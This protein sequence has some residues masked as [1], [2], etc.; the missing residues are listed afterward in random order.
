MR[1]KKG[2]QLNPGQ[3]IIPVG[4][5]N[6]PEPHEMDA[7]MIL[8]RH[9]Q[10]TIEFLAPVDDFKR[11]TADV[12]MLGVIWEIK[13]PKG[14]SKSTIGTQFSRASR[15]SKNIVL[16][17]RRTKLEYERIEKKVIL[18]VKQRTALNKVILINKS[19]KVI[20]MKK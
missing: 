17:T 9:Y 6:P 3:V 4:H 5:P 13:C 1:K 10:A 8:A 7:A 14:A 12:K 2:K 16:D 11:K 19:G 18:E 15:Q 20:E